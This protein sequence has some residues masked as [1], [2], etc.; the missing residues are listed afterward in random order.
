[1]DIPAT[2]ETETK[3]MLRLAGERKRETARAM[4]VE[5]AQ[6]L[7]DYARQY[8]MTIAMENLLLPQ[9]NAHTALDLRDMI[10]RCKRDN[11]RALFDCGHAHRVGADQGDFI[12]TLG[13]LVCHVHLND[14]DGTCDLHQQIGEGTI[15]FDAVFVA[16]REIGYQGALVMETSYRDSD[17]LLESSRLLNHYLKAGE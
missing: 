10:L 17:D 7:A 14:N 12:R 9:E 13:N 1:M 16:L 3:Q 6:E 8:N 15:D 2:D 4:T 11:V 5:I